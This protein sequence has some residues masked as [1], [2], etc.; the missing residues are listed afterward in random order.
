MKKTRKKHPDLRFAQPTHYNFLQN[1][2]FLRM[3]S[4]LKFEVCRKTDQSNRIWCIMAVNIRKSYVC[5]AVE[6]TN[7]E[8]ILAVMNTT[9]LIIEIRPKKN[10]ARTGFE[11][12]TSTIPLR[13]FNRSAHIWFSYVHSLYSPLRRFIWIQHND[14]LPVGFLVQLVEVSVSQGS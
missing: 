13:F 10:Q 4:V 12:M 9:E 14:R 11:L 8:S 6:V 5:T 3:L 7:T 1:D 2:Q